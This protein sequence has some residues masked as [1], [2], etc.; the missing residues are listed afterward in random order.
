MEFIKGLNF[1]YQ[2]MLIGIGV[3]IIGVIVLFIE[4]ISKKRSPEEIK[5][6]YLVKNNVRTSDNPAINNNSS[7]YTNT[8]NTVNGE[9]K[10]NSTVPE[11][12]KSDEYP[13]MSEQNDI[14]INPS[15]NNGNSDLM[16]MYK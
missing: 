3:F 13:K 12:K 7:V 15:N 6:E 14:P 5:N 2:V 1:G 8:N 4:N 9:I 16:N 10:L 11:E